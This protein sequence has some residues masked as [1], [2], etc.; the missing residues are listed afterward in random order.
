VTA[1]A[2]LIA[3]LLLALS[4][5]LRHFVCASLLAA[6]A[7]LLS[8]LAPPSTLVGAAARL[9]ALD[10]EAWQASSWRRLVSR[11]ASELA[12]RI[13]QRIWSGTRTC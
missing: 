10:V 4:A 8:L 7:W 6:I 11:L 5:G 1:V 2:A 3:V 13:D 12:E 9:W